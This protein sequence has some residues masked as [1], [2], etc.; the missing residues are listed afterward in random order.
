MSEELYLGR[1]KG[2]LTYL[3]KE[4]L[5]KFAWLCAVR[6]LPLLGTR[7]NFDFWKEKKRQKYIYSI[8]HILDLIAINFVRTN[9]FSKIV[10]SISYLDVFDAADDV[11]GVSIYKTAA[12]AANVAY[13]AA[14]ASSAGND[15]AYIAK[16]TSP[17]LTKMRSSSYST[18]KHAYI[19]FN[20]VISENMKSYGSII[21]EDLE[22]IKDGK[23][24][25]IHLDVY[26]EIWDNFQNALKA[27]GCEY[28]GKLYQNIF[29]NQFELD[30]DALKRRLSVP[31]EIRNQGAKEVADYLQKL[32]K[33]AKR[34]NE[35]RIIILGDKGAGKTC[36]A[37]RL[38][39][40][41][42]EMT[43][44]EES[45]AGVDTTLWK[46]EDEN[47]NVRIWDFAGHTVTHAVH[48][49]FLSERC[50][51]IIVYSGRQDDRNILDKLR[52]WLDHMQNYG[53]NSQAIILVNKRDQ[54]RVDIPVNTLNEQYSI[55]G[56]Y[57]FSILNDTKKLDKFRNDVARFIKSNPSWK[58]QQIPESYYLVKDELEKIFIN[59][60]TKKGPEHITR[61][62]FDRIA[63][64]YDV[65]DIEVL[66]KDLHFLGVSLW[67][68]ELVEFNTL[69]LNPEW[70]S[71]GV[72]KIINWVNDKKRYSISL[73]EFNLVFKSTDD[74]KRYPSD[75]YRFLFKL[76]KHCELA[77]STED[78]KCLI[79]PHLLK[80][81]RPENLPEFA[82]GE[83]LMLRYKSE[84]PLPSNSI[85]VFIVRHNEQIKQINGEDLVWRYGVVLE[86]GKGST[87]L[88]REED[89]TISVF[90]KGK[91]KTDYISSLRET[92]NDIFN[93]YKSEKPELQY[94]IE[95]YGEI[96]EELNA[97]A[98]IWLPDSKILNHY[99]DN[100]PYYD[101]KTRQRIPMAHTVNI[102]NIQSE[103]A[104]LGG[105]GH[106]LMKNVFNFHDC[107]ISLQGNL[108]DLSRVLTDAGNNE[109]AK[110]LQGAADALKQLEGCK[111]PEEAKRSGLPNKVKRVL[112]DLGDEKSKLHKVV[113]GVKHGI[114]IGQ[115]IAEGYNGFA[116][117]LGLPQVPRPFLKKG[118]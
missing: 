85:S 43:T 37:R 29:D 71:H 79:I 69:I 80:E 24:P 51:Y 66:I 47:I 20:L 76:M 81:D 75:K 39:N 101:D 31:E 61:K 94:R 68:P 11:D 104:L 87:A 18:V 50:L 103:N 49:F 73:D 82:L 116:Q 62:E 48:Q 16:D 64:K 53:G 41:E 25:Q 97:L 96:L 57:D 107:N 67:Y 109:E 34:L 42:A 58:S 114:S 22:Y 106:H 40:P 32:E 108:N 117:W 56:V 35:A 36:I 74:K 118:K 9:H 112:E 13:A 99:T 91:D 95:R 46:L 60:E 98:P 92:L 33:G 115:D 8:F 105:T 90:V 1:L 19:A 27:E 86:D 89:R 70:I 88:V 102:Y 111:D 77:Y 6:A 55:A 2:E 12:A 65:D 28:W 17:H 45:T 63:K 38:V 26:D 10:N 72:Y 54:H 21:W 5:A 78:E 3:N 113:K 110:E 84:Q 100:E 83:S 7:G 59:D 4:H 93:S 30:Q 44:D 14:Y 15:V 23:K 52:Y